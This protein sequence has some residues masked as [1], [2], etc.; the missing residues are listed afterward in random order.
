LLYKDEGGEF[1]PKLLTALSRTVLLVCRKTSKS[2]HTHH[3]TVA[4]QRIAGR[5]LEIGDCFV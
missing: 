1:R 5:S 4:R 2:A 3:D